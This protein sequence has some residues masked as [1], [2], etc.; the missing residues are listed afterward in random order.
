MRHDNIMISFIDD[1][2]GNQH[3][4]DIRVTDSFS[5][6]SR[7]EDR[8]AKLIVY[9]EPIFHPDPWLCSEVVTSAV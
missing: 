9:V 7:G 4:K 3:V 2:H 8:R 5:Q 6:R 1:P